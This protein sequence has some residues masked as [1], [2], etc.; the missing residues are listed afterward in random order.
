MNMKTLAQLLVAMIFFS[1]SWFPLLYVEVLDH[2]DDGPLY[3]TSMIVN[4]CAMFGG[5][6]LMFLLLRKVSL[7]SI[8]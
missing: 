7:D 1:V 2:K 3:L 5:L 6:Y 8:A 4:I